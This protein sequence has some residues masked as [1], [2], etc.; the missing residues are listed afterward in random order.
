MSGQDS[1]SSAAELGPVDYLVVDFP[2]GVLAGDGFDSLLDLVASGTIYVLDLEF[3]GRD[4]HGAV[5]V[6]DVAEVAVP[7]GVDLS[8]I[9]GSSSGLLDRDDLAS[10][11]E[12]IQ[13]GGVAAVLVYEN[14]WAEQFAAAMGRSGGRVV[15]QNRV[16]VDD[17]LAAFD[18]VEST[19][20][21]PTEGN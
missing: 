17:L 18:R 9:Q 8:A 21:A 14:V 2:A 4:D 20:P 7:E 6:V 13:P 10:V 19:V 11:G 16:D 3:V 1:M 5:R 12:A 15:S